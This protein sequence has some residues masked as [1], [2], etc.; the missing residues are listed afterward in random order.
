MMAET[1]GAIGSDPATLAR[2]AL[3]PAPIPPF[4][5]GP[6][7]KPKQA[8]HALWVGNLPPAANILDLKEHSSYNA[9]QDIVSLFLIAKS[10][11]A[12]V[13]CR[14]EAACIAAMNRFHDS[15]FQAFISPSLCMYL[16]GTAGRIA[17]F[18]SLRKRALHMAAH[19]PPADRQVLL[20]LARPKCSAAQAE[21]MHT[22]LQT[23]SGCLRQR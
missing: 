4:P 16:R 14:S 8:G 20:E 23:C 9:T 10:N 18:W 15:R 5:R 6:S 12:F 19:L 13:N 2:P 21:A 22:D 7:Q 11:C 1:E 3:E 17:L